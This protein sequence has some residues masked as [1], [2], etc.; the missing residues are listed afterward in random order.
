M[1]CCRSG[2]IGIISRSSF[3]S[4]SSALD[5]LL[6]VKPMPYLRAV[7]LRSARS[8][9]FASWSSGEPL[10]CCTASE[11]DCSL[12]SSPSSFRLRKTFRLLLAL[13]SGSA[14]SVVLPSLSDSEWSVT[15][16]LSESAAELQRSTW[17]T[18]AP[19]CA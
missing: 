9:W 18:D 19:R 16:A 10:L 1:C 7:G 5:A 6:L 13:N 2:C 4:C 11:S 8:R 15:S 14:M 3:S 17:T 12:S